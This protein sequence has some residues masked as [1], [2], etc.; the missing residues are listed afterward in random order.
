MSLPYITVKI[1][2]NKPRYNQKGTS[3]NKNLEDQVEIQDEYL[4]FFYNCWVKCINKTSKKYDS[5]GLLVSIKNNIVFLRSLHDQVLKE[6]YTDNTVFF[7]KKTTE[8]YKAMQEI[9]MEKEKMVYIRNKYKKLEKE[10]KD[11][12][13]NKRRFDTMKTRLF[14][15]VSDGKV[16]ILI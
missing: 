11:F 16:K 15:L 13:E 3:N 5:G 9:Q 1:K 12:E 4:K 14:K 2:S 7:V 8:N 10:I 6:F